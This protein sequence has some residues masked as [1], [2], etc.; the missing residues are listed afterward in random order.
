MTETSQTPGPARGLN[1]KRVKLDAFTLTAQT[2]A[3]LSEETVAEYVHSVVGGEDLDPGVAYRVGK[4][5]IL[6]AGHHRREAYRRAGKEDMPCEVR[7][8][9]MWDAVSFSLLSNRNFRGARVTTADKKEAVR[10]ALVYGYEKTDSV[11]SNLCGVDHKTVGA[12]RKEMEESGEIPKATIRVAADGSE[13]KMIE[14]P[15]T[16]PQK[17]VTELPAVDH[18]A[19]TAAHHLDVDDGCDAI[20]FPEKPTATRQKIPA[21]EPQREL[22]TVSTLKSFNVRHSNARDALVN[23]ARRVD[24][25]KPEDQ[26][27]HRKAIEHYYAIGQLLDQWQRPATEA[28]CNSVVKLEPL[29]VLMNEIQKALAALSRKY[30]EIKK[31]DPISHKSIVGYLDDMSVMTDKWRKPAVAK[32]A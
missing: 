15:A 27:S 4:D 21:L 2:R 26:A 7:S 30:D 10:K 20:E 18:S 3:A 22:G 16:T 25:L 5:L 8:G 24:D 32:A 28:E 17:N 29:G 11:L 19:D 9:S 23:F 13:R 31:F 12:R 14:R 1:I 6:A